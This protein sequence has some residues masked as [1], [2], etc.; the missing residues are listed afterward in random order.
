MPRGGVF[1]LLPAR[2]QA[3]FFETVSIIFLTVIAEDLWKLGYIRNYRLHTA[4]LVKLRKIQGF[5]QESSL[6]SAAHE[7]MQPQQTDA[8]L[9]GVDYRQH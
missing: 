9:F 8:A 5:I 2:S 4:G 6:E 3:L 7:V 1:N